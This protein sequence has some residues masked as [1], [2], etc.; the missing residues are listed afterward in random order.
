LI[1]GPEHDLFSLGTAEAGAEALRAAATQADRVEF[2]NRPVNES[3][4]TRALS[5]VD[6]SVSRA[7]QV[8]LDKLLTVVPT[9]P[10]YTREILIPGQPAT[11]ARGWARA[12]ARIQRLRT[13]I[14]AEALASAWIHPDP[15]AVAEIMGE[16]PLGLLAVGARQTSA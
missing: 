8:L 11:D 7:D 1:R 10:M 3:A 9:I 15:A 4:V 12:G 6:L 5:T 16:I 2:A 14:A 13:A